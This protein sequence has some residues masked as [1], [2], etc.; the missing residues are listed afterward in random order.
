IKEPEYKKGEVIVKLKETASVLNVKSEKELQGIS[1]DKAEVTFE[2]LA[3]ASI[4]EPIE[5]INDKYKITKIEKI[6]KGVGTPREEL[7]DLK[8]KFSD[9]IREGTRAINEQEF[10]KN[11]LS[12]YYVL[13][14]TEDV[15]VKEIV[16]SLFNKEG[17]EYAEPNYIAY[18]QAYI[19]SDPLFSEQWALNNDTDT[20]IDAPEVWDVT[21]GSDEVIIAVIDTGVDYTHSELGG[22]IGEGCK[23]IGGHDFYNNDNDPMD[24]NGHGTH[25]AGITA[26]EQDNSFGISGVC[27]NCRLL[28]LKFLDS[29]GYGDVADGVESIQYAV[30]NG[31]R[32]LNNSWGSGGYSQSLSDVIEWANSQV[33]VVIASAGNSNNGMK[34]Y[35]ASFP[36]VISVAATDREDHKASYSNYG[37]T[38]DVS[39]PGGDIADNQACRYPSDIAILSTITSG[40]IWDYWGSLCGV[41]EDVPIEIAATPEPSP[42][43]SPTP[44]QDCA[45][46][47]G[48]EHNGYCWFLGAGGESCSSV[49][50]THGGCASGN[51]NDDTSCTVMNHF[52]N[53]T[54]DRSCGTCE[55]QYPYS[56]DDPFN[57]APRFWAP[58]HRC[59]YRAPDI[60]PNC[61]NSASNTSNRRVCACGL[62]PTSTPTPTAI[63]T[64]IPTVEITY[65]HN[66]DTVSETITVT[67]DATDDVSVLAVD[68]M[69]CNLADSD[70]TLNG[71]FIY[72]G[73]DSRAPYAIDFDLRDLE[74]GQYIL[75]ATVSDYDGNRGEDSIL[76]NVDNSI[77]PI[78]PTPTPVRPKY[79]GLSGTSMAS[80]H[81]AGI[82]GL[83]LSRYPKVSPYQ[84]EQMIKNGVDGIDSD[85]YIGRGRVNAFSS[86]SQNPP[87]GIAIIESL[88]NRGIISN[89]QEIVGTAIGGE[90]TLEYGYGLYPRSWN[91]VSSGI[92]TEGVLGVLNLPEESPLGLYTIKLTVA[93]NNGALSIDEKR[94]SLIDYPFGSLP[95]WPQKMTTLIRGYSS[96]AVDD[97]D[98]DGNNDVVITG[99]GIDFF[100]C[101]DRACLEPHVFAW[102]YRGVTLPGWPKYEELWMPP[103][104]GFYF[105]NDGNYTSPV[106]I[107]LDGNGTKEVIVGS[108][109]GNVCVWNHDGTNFNSNWPIQ[110]GYSIGGYWRRSPL[111]IDMDNNGDYEIFTINNDGK[112]IYAWNYDGTSYLP[113]KNGI[114]YTAPISEWGVPTEYEEGEVSLRGLSAVDVNNDGYME[115]LFAF[116]CPTYACQPDGKAGIIVVDHNGEVVWSTSD[117]RLEDT[118]ENIAIGDLDHDGNAEIVYNTAINRNINVLKSDGSPYG[119]NWPYNP[120][121]YEDHYIIPRNVS[122]ADVSG[123]GYLEILSPTGMGKL[124]ILDFR[125][126]LINSIE[127]PD[128]ATVSFPRYSE[129]VVTDIDGDKDKE[130][131]LAYAERAVSDLA[132]Y[133]WHHD[134][135]MVNGWPLVVPG[136]EDNIPEY[137][138]ISTPTVTDLDKDGKTDLVVASQNGYVFAFKTDG[139]YDPDTIQWGRYKHS[140]HSAKEPHHLKY[141]IFPQ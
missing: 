2:D 45:A 71:H 27:P 64:T 8:E 95:G 132:V 134:G 111:V 89:S 77:E 14:F 23:V 65:P 48:W 131:I 80:P 50:S 133:A 1:I 40:A 25:V 121:V 139:D 60:N 22:C 42:T 128:A 36:L 81:V 135:T 83:I 108:M 129:V 59:F 69:Y 58:F 62:I 136:D 56:E 104:N 43:V 99:S 137:G 130:I 138:T 63:D 57:T 123:D 113:E 13:K 12:K 54:Y 100:A 74:N 117:I 5:N 47:G 19:P 78:T 107:D 91:L 52:Y 127:I 115:I 122:I 33:T 66:G 30:E 82:A 38:V 11:D 118:P 51:W 34:L 105:P 39:A 7:N 97:I 70:C 24:D 32:V 125:G 26:A 101:S 41:T 53:Q 140:D 44:T 126:N 21:K 20:D 109:D 96:P 61:N 103:M 110:T 88:E 6:F 94:V 9:E 31:A 90:Y 17:I 119:Y 49:C 16:G 76:V 29:E 67:A 85:K 102:D 73:S 106:L 84:V 116:D 92:S 18:A 28:A 46:Q 72:V 68:L 4:P 93:D 55:Q 87:Q 98:G 112:N 35:P 120:G 114:F 124:L 37:Y 79:I 10:L 75:K 86:L 15:P 141:Q 3:E